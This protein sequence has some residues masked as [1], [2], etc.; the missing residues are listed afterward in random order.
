[1]NTPHPHLTN[2]YEIDISAQ[3]KRSYYGQLKTVG[4]QKFSSF[5]EWI[6]YITSS[7]FIPSFIAYHYFKNCYA[8]DDLKS[9]LVKTIQK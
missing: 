1:M 7:F 2:I 6:Y 5:N 3:E 8:A 9:K 4:Y